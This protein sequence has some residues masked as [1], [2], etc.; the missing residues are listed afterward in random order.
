MRLGDVEI[1][2]QVLTAYEEGTLVLFTGA[3]I[4]MAPPS[5]LPGFAALTAEIVG[6]VGSDLDPYSDDW[7]DRLDVLLGQ[8]DEDP[9][10]AVHELT[11]AIVTRADSVPNNVHKSLMRIAAKSV[12]RIVTTNY[13]LH[14]ETAG[15]DLQLPIQTFRAPAL[16]L[17]DDFSGMVYLHGAADQEAGKL[18]VTDRDFGHAYLREA[19][20]ARF[21]ERMFGKYTVLF[22]GYSHG[23]VVMKYLG[24]A[25]G[26]DSSR[27]VLT[28][29]END[30]N[31][32]RLDVTPIPYSPDNNHQALADC[33]ADWAD[34]GEMGLIQHRQRIR[35]L[36]AGQ[37]EATP[38]E[39]SYLE[40]SL[41]RPERARFFT[42]AAEH[43]TWLEWA[44]EQNSFQSV[45]SREAPRDEVEQKLRHLLATWFVDRFVLDPNAQDE[46]WAALTKLGGRLSLHLWTALASGLHPAP[47]PRPPHHRRWLYLLL[48]QNQAGSD[49]ELLSY[50]LM[51]SDWSTDRTEIIE[52]FTHLTAPRTTV[53]QGYGYL[54]HRFQISPYGDQHWLMEAWTTQIHPNLDVPAAAEILGIV[55]RNLVLHYRRFHT[56]VD[57]TNDPYTLH[58][59]A[60]QPDAQD[61]FPEAIDTLVDVLRDCSVFLADAG[62]PAVE[63]I[64]ERWFASEYALLR[65]LAVHLTRVRDDLTADDKLRRAL[66]QKVIADRPAR[67]EFFCLIADTAQD[68]SGEVVDRMVAESAAA[69]EAEGASAYAAFT[70]LEWLR[71]NGVSTEA[72]VA[73]LNGIRSA[74]PE[75][76]VSEHPQFRGWH[77]FDVFQSLPPLDTATFHDRVTAD[78]A[79]AFAFLLQFREV[80][81]PTRGRSSWGDAVRLVADL[82][83]TNPKDAFVLWEPV[84]EERELQDAVIMALAYATD[85]D[86]QSR[87]LRLMLGLELDRHRS[88]VGNFLSTVVRE[89]IAGWHTAPENDAFVAAV[90]AAA[91][92]TSG[93]W[94]NWTSKVVNDPVGHLVDYWYRGFRTA[95]TDAAETWSGLRPEDQ[96]LL[97]TIL[98]DRTSRGDIAL[99]ELA[100]LIHVLDAADSEWCR[101]HL[102]P[103]RHWSDPSTARPFWSGVL[104][105]ARWNQGLVA[106]GLDK[107]LL[108]T[109]GHLDELDD[110]LHKRW[111]GFAAAVALQTDQPETLSWIRNLIAAATP[112]SRVD[113]AEAVRDLLK[114][115]PPE[116]TSATWTHWMHAY[117]RSRANDDPKVLTPDEGATMAEWIPLLP[118]EYLEPAIILATARP[119]G[120]N[121]HSHLVSDFSAESL[122]ANAPAIGRLL[123]H[124]MTH[125]QLPF[126]GQQYLKPILEVLV[127]QS[128]DWT[129]LRNEALRLGIEL[130][131]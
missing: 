46:A 19:W 27:Y 90:W 1:P 10:T 23:D 78:P 82:V 72:L 76:E 92:T 87:A 18:I 50:A 42:Q 13:D 31:W 81:L 36:V 38:A 3:G 17:G 128:G 107:G 28:A 119:A 71:T 20:A 106:A 131:D 102:L 118:S 129:A 68:A 44:T 65:R 45:F 105:F 75:F 8:L 32:R 16:P 122:A 33:L 2:E 117:W 111:A 110:D 100:G 52:L 113:W 67:Q 24:L 47:T 120:F 37:A 51:D 40:D 14:L 88:A 86:V 55:E 95:W 63:Q 70:L 41:R 83:R 11:K 121:R 5:G 22:V 60:I 74:H 124:L 103:L 126:Y 85:S 91:A 4:S 96:E 56:M 123:T 43:P 127:A 15:G 101:E 112:K 53:A 77:E 93:K 115:L 30:P 62:S 66:D 61:Q 34:L 97:S 21:L 25:L 108:E 80:E 26:Q 116:A 49:Q 48:D 104:T 6:K 89:N 59:S 7:K 125:T 9:A 130:T 57:P 64:A 73:A 99:T 84:S 79:E 58:R 54:P 29:D 39:L 35:Q 94:E 98:A 12:P 109:A 69:G 114:E